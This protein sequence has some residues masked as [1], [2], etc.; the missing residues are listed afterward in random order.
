M[1]ILDVRHAC[2]HI[3]I[4]NCGT[5]SSVALAMVKEDGQWFI[6]DFVTPGLDNSSEKNDMKQYIKE[7]SKE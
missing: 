2:A 1:E 5:K 3:R 4:T 7:R 6:D